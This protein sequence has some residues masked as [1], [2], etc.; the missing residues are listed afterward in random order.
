[1][2]TQEKNTVLNLLKQQNGEFRKFDIRTSE[3]RGKNNKH[4]WTLYVFE[5]SRKRV[6][7]NDESK[8]FYYEADGLLYNAN[9]ITRFAD[10]V[11]ALS[12]VRIQ[13]DWGENKDM[14]GQ[15]CVKIW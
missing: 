3:E 4:D 9:L 8:G 14:N 2:T 6:D 11:N 15:P 1:M 12:V 10:V 13:E 7:Y 5:L